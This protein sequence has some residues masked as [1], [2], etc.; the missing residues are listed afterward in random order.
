MLDC[1]RE[2]NKIVPVRFPFK[3]KSHRSKLSAYKR[4]QVLNELKTMVALNSPEAFDFNAELTELRLA[5]DALFQEFLTAPT[6]EMLQQF[7]RI[8]ERRNE[9]HTAMDAEI[10]PMPASLETS[11]SVIDI[12]PCSLEEFRAIPKP[13]KWTYI[14]GLF[15]RQSAWI[16]PGICGRHSALPKSVVNQY[17]LSTR[18]ILILEGKIE[19]KKPDPLHNTPEASHE[20]RESQSLETS[21]EKHFDRMSW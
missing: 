20:V 21:Y 17:E 13:G 8:W 5:E 15:G 7:A 1:E 10:T 3:C 11:K 6:H 18:Q 2:S 4:W 14:P 12:S 19:I 16:C 9:I